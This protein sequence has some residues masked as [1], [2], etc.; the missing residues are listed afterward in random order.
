VP[1]V[2]L[3]PA[4]PIFFVPPIAAFEIKVSNGDGGP[5]LKSEGTIFHLREVLDA[6]PFTASTSAPP[7][8]LSSSAI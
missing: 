4:A 6:S 7:S 8:L 2:Q 3:V 1:I 5:H